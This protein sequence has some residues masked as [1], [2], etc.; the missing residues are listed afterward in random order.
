MSRECSSRLGSRVAIIFEYELSIDDDE[1]NSFVVVEGIRE[2]RLVD[3][4]LGIEDRNF[5]KHSFLE[6]AAV[7]DS[8]LSGVERCHLAD[9]VFE[10]E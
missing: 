2:V 5:R 8:N 3:D 6:E 4:H 10:L 9:P 7:V 1:A